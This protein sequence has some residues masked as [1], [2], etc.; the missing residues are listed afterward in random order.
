MVPRVQRRPH[1]AQIGCPQSRSNAGCCYRCVGEQVVLLC[2]DE[3]VS[4]WLLLRVRYGIWSG[5]VGNVRRWQLPG[6]REAP[7]E[8]AG[9]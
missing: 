8:W 9:L 3:K 7:L 6:V 1:H 5:T 4:E 2:A